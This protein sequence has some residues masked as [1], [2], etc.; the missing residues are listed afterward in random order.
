MGDWRPQI[1][2]SILTADFGHLDRVVRKLEKAGVDRLHLDVMDGHFVP[3]ITF[4]PDVVAAFRRL[5]PLPLDVHLMIS[6]AGPLRRPV[7]GRASRRPSPSTSRRTTS[8][9][10]VADTLRAIQA[11]G[12]GAGLAVSPATPVAAVD[13]RTSTGW[14]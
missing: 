4:G 8:S 10:R 6:R 13:A 1:A 11:A 7:P 12:A 3:N 5:T 14:T 9:D 2:A